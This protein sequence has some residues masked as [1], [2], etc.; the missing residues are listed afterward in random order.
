MPQ[1]YQFTAANY[2]AKK[3]KICCPW[4]GKR[5]SPWTLVFKPAFED[6]C[7]AQVD[8]FAS[9]YQMLVTE[10]DIGGRHG[11]N[12]PNLTATLNFQ[13]TT[14]RQIRMGREPGLL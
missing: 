9:W 7:R 10:T 8:Q 5:G 11:A 1:S 12:H 6:G 13:S 4:N 14:A 2:D 3:Y